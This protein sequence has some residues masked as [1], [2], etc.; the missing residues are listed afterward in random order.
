MLRCDEVT[1]LCAS[2]GL[3]RASIYV[4]VAVR[5]HLVMCRWCSRYIRE[6]AAIGSATR[7]LTRETKDEAARTEALVGRVLSEVSRVRT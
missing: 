2:E 6:L 7:E 5:V 3:N 4:R 1:R